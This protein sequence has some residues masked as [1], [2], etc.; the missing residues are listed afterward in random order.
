MT[1][2]KYALL[3]AAV[4]CGSPFTGSERAYRAIAPRLIERL[5][6]DRVSLYPM[7]LR[8]PCADYPA[9]LLHYDTVVSVSEELRRN[10]LAAYAKGEFPVTIGG[11]H[12]VAM[13]TLAAAGETFGADD[14]ALIYID[15]HTDINTIE[16]SASHMIHGMDLAEALGLTV[17]RLKIGRNDADIRGEN[18]HFIGPRSVD[19]PEWGILEQ[20]GCTCHT[21][22]EVRRRGMNAVVEDVLRAVRGKKTVISF[23][24]DVLNPSI[25]R[26]TGYNIPGGLV[27]IEVENALLMF[28]EEADVAAFECVEYSPAKDPDGTDL[29]TLLGILACAIR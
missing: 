4:S 22:A 26:A 27:P 28:F 13:G 21:G 17:P 5:G 15:A 23:D 14:L 3:E 2:N 16:S 20:A 24:V 6:A 12:S 7:E 25:F 1:P 19:D 9:D 10:W 11:D 8:T 29:E 18:I